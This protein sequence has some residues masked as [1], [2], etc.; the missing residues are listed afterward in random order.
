MHKSAKL[1]FFI[2]CQLLYSDTISVTT[3]STDPNETGSLPNALLIAVD[4][5]IIDCS[6]I[7]GQTIFV[8]NQ[9]I[10]AI[11]YNLTSPTSSLTILG[12]GVTIDGGGM[13]PA[14]SLVQGSLT[15]SD[16]IIANG[17]SK[18]GNGGAGYAGGG[19]AT[20]GGGALYIHSGAVMTISAVSLNGNQA[21]GGNGG[22]GSAGGSGGGG[23]G[24]GG[25][26]GGHASA[27]SGAAA[28]AGGGGGGNN[29]GIFGGPDLGSGGLNSFGNFGGAGGGGERPHNGLAGNGG[30]VAATAAPSPARSGGS[31]G[32][33]SSTEGGGGGGGGGSGG[34]GSAGTSASSGGI[35]GSP[36][37]GFDAG[38]TYGAGGGGAG[39]GGGA[40]G[41]GASGGGGGCGGTL[42]GPGGDGGVLSGGGGGSGNSLRGN[43]GGDGGFGAGGGAG[44]TAGLGTYGGGDAG[45]AITTQ[46]AGG[47]GGSGFGGAIFVQ[48]GALLIVEDGVG[49]SGNSTIA[50]TGGTAP[51]NS[52]GNGSSLGE[53]IFVQSG[54]SV[55]F[56]ING[57]VSIPNPIEGAGSLSH[58]T[59]PGVTLL[60]MG[61]VKLN[62][63]NTYLG[64][65]LVEAGTLNLN[66]SVSGDVHLEPSGALSGNATVNGSIYNQGT[67]SPGNSIGEVFTTNL[68]LYPTSIY[69]VEIDS[70]GASDEI[71]A[72]GFAQIDGGVVVTPDDL[73]F[74]T[75][76]TYTIL[77]TSGGVTGSF[78][79]LT[80]S[81]PSF[82]TLTYNP[83]TVQLTYLPLEAI[84]LTGNALKVAKCFATLSPIPGSDVAT[85]NNALHALSFDSIQSAFEQMDPAQFSGLTN[86][87]LLDAILVRSTYT[88]HLADIP[89]DQSTSFWIDGIGQ[90]QKQ[91]HH[92]GYRDT[93]VGGTI[94]VDHSI[95]NFVLGMA[96]SY[97]Y[98]MFHS[99]NQAHMSSYYGGLY[100]AWNPNR[101]YMNMSFLGAYNKFHSKR[102][103]DFGTIDRKARA[104]FSGNEWLAH[105]GFGYQMSPYC[106]PY[107]D[108]DY[109]QGHRNSYTEEGADSLDLHMHKK[110]AALFQGEVGVLLST[111]Y[112]TCSGL[113]IPSLT[114]AYVNQ[115]PC[116]SKNFRANFVNS[117]CVFTTHGKNYERNLFAPRLDFTYRTT[118]NTFSIYYDGEIGSGYW[119]QDIGFDLTFRF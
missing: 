98:D 92:F 119:A 20:G 88:H 76:V 16:L 30:S 52:G 21:Q 86:V 44:Y 34:G 61:I 69:D 118:R 49:F 110:N 70:A 8:D 116:Y 26:P 4:G 103:L 91:Q 109:V 14:F 113:F 43:K 85:V 38:Q 83:F 41:L 19:G 58:I 33:C 28:G 29:G 1:L 99:A 3:T 94:G 13:Y 48:Q 64:G 81:V 15:I 105:L 71:I 11:G 102:T 79:T 40:A 104:N 65:T 78:A 73:N 23:G 74:A 84:G 108:L 107:I 9:R 27:S 89:C 63:A 93:T 68:Y 36:G 7:T 22:A 80:S 35:G 90:W 46:P 82:M 10:P 25:G 62:G 53:D 54:G 17:L 37:P 111:T 72:S 47:G 31:G 24:F 75:P 59:G 100:G 56:Q 5:S 66:G 45:L 117:T 32:A 50:G 114:L 55:T 95:E 97:T 115:T 2:C 106:T 51:V 6:P 18:G 60:G 12:S 67:I 101:F 96:F 42:T 77:S 112:S 57:I 87:Q 39:G